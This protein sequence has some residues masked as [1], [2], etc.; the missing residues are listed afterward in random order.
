MHKKCPRCGGTLRGRHEQACSDPN[1]LL[2]RL[3][4]NDPCTAGCG[5]KPNGRTMQQW[6]SHEEAC[7][8]YSRISREDPDLFE[9]WQAGEWCP[10]ECGVHSKS[11][12]LGSYRI[13]IERHRKLQRESIEHIRSG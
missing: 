6:A 7:H 10:F 3:R 9:R 8:G 13:H 5:A 11:M 2:N 12:E 4:R 1:S